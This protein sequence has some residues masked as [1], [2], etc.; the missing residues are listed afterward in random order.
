MTTPPLADVFPVP[1]H[2]FVAVQ[3]KTHRFIKRLKHQLRFARNGFVATMT[4]IGALHS[5]VRI[6]QVN[7]A[8][9]SL[10]QMGFSALR[11]C[12]NIEWTGMDRCKKRHKAETKSKQMR[13][14]YTRTVCMKSR[15]SKDNTITSNNISMIMINSFSS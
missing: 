5:G 10:P 1:L 4:R 14:K 8:E 12:L 7:D 15:S 13:Q 3:G 11:N 2:L 6:Y 9:S